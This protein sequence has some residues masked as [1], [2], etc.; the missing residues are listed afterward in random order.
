MIWQLILL[1]L[2]PPH[3]WWAPGTIECRMS[4]SQHTLRYH[5]RIVKL[6]CKNCSQTLGYS[7]PHSFWIALPSWWSCNKIWNH[8]VPT[9]QPIDFQTWPWSRWACVVWGDAKWYE[10]LMCVTVQHFIILWYWSPLHAIL[11]T[12][13][14]VHYHLMTLN[15]SQIFMCNQNLNHNIHV[16]TTR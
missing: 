2:A 1:C 9:Y 7:N 16:S 6:F 13:I 12:G 10:L 14:W 11:Y 4:G 5:R 8:R 3:S 15:V